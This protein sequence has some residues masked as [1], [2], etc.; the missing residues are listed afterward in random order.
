VK[1]V[2]SPGGGLMLQQRPQGCDQKRAETE[3]IDSHST[4]TPPPDGPG[5]SPE[6]QQPRQKGKKTRFCKAK[7]DRYR[8]LV[9]R[10]VEEVRRNP[11]TFD[12]DAA[13]VPA[14]VT[15]KPEAKEK[16]WATVMQFARL[17]PRS[18]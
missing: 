12:V 16:L 18:C 13:D 1:V 14:S 3:D 6:D 4:C 7:R 10:L 15:M 2:R 5:S 11:L 8:K 9:E 17:P